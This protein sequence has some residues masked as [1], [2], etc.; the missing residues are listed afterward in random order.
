MYIRLNII[1]LFYFIILY[2]INTKLISRLVEHVQ[3]VNASAP[4]A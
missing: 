1:L 4:N 3:F 2:I